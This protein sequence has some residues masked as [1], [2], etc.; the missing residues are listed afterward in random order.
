MTRA[1]F[2]NIAIHPQASFHARF[3][4]LDKF[5]VP[6][7][8]H[9]EYELAWIIK[10]NGKRYVGKNMADFDDDDLVF[11]GSNLPHSW[12][13]ETFQK[14][15]SGVQSVVIQFRDDFMG[16]DF[17]SK[18]EMHAIQT[19]MK[20]SQAGIRFSLSTVQKIKPRI[21][22]LIQEEN[23]FNR[24][25]L[26]LQILNFL[27]NQPDY[28]LLDNDATSIKNTLLGRERLNRALGYIIDNFKEE[29]MLEKVAFEANMSPN[30]FCKYFKKTT[31]KTF[32]ETVIDYRINYS[33]QQLLVTDKPVSEVA[34]ESGFGDVSHFHKVFKKML[35]MSPL[36]YR[37]SFRKDL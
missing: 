31:G 33:V 5:T 23:N 34:F 22:E 15:N 20:R 8:F 37:K 30:A 11:L 1:Q 16:S 25:Q 13:S 29:I 14:D 19:L 35:K 3:Y 27:A 4:E 2:E 9:P 21:M 7:H 18:P 12:K 10:G 24:L 32:M 28:F 6:Y 26:M 17:F 36:V